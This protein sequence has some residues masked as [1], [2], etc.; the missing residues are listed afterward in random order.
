MPKNRGKLLLLK[1]SKESPRKWF[2]K[3]KKGLPRV[4][5]KVF[6]ITGTTSGTGFR[7]ILKALNLSIN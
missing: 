2:P 3:F 1:V 5:G 6:A 4:D 7:D